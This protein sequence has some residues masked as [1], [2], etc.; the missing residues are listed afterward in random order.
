M[1]RQR[2]RIRLLM[3]IILACGGLACAF[4]EF[5]PSDPMGHEF[6]LSETHKA[7]SDSVRWSK[8]DEA[9]G[10]VVPAERTAY[11][12]QM[13]DF[14]AG[15]FTDWSAEPWEFDD[16]ETRTRATINVTYMGYSMANPIE[17][18]VGEKQTW[19]R[20]DRGNNWQVESKFTGLDQFGGG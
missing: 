14:A 7:Y 6:S 10:F 3:G 8:F 4:G 1:S 17:F 11:R 18:K 12:A 5:R 20:E 13:P 15:R 9:S 16:P 19:S 2:R